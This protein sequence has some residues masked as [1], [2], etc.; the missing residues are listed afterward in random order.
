M[1]KIPIGFFDKSCKERLYYAGEAHGL[2][3]GKTRS[4]KFRYIYG[5][6][7]LSVMHNCFVLCPKGQS[8]AVSARYRRDVLKH[9]VKI[10]NPFGVF[11]KELS[12]F[13]HV[14]Y[15]PVTSKLDPKS[16]TFAVDADNLTEGWMPFTGGDQHWVVGGRKFTSGV[17]MHLRE[18]MD[19]WSLP[20]IYGV[21]CDPNIYSFCEHAVNDPDTNPLVVTRL[22]RFAGKE[23]GENREIRS[24]VSAAIQ[25]LSWVDNDPIA[26]NM[27][28]ST[29]DFNDMRKRRMTVYVVLPE[30]YLMTC[31]SWMRTITNA[32][33]DACL[34][35]G[36]SQYPILGLLMEFATT[37]GNLNSV[38]TLNSMGAG[39]KC[40][41]ISE[42]QDLNQLI[43]LKPKSWQTWL[44]NA[45]FH[46]YLGAGIGDLF[47]AGHVSKMTG[48]IQIPSV[49]RTI[50]DNQGQPFQLASGALDAVNRSLRSLSGAGGTQVS[51]G[52]RQR[53]Y[54]L[55]EEIIE[56]SEEMLVFVEGLKGVIKAG[57]KGYYQDPEFTGRFDEDPFHAKRS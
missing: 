40:Q 48:E 9:D 16:K 53:P 12:E 54:M 25:G 42:F 8:P 51:I 46:A 30:N 44:A 38:D 1:N 13:E 10:L 32:F 19:R 55:P 43:E 36:A 37:V 5:P 22:G 17:A 29:I 49:S 56:L 28:C 26:D 27:R 4:G 50:N 18:Q 33:A 52:S 35:P 39:H 34:Q 11:A 7:L 41:L 15:C 2:V 57:K 47:T 21:I 20:D 3:I 6:I 45:G 23:A 24:I 31:S 14:K